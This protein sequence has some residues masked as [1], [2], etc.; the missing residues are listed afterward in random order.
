M[1]VASNLTEGVHSDCVFLCVWMQSDLSLPMLFC[2]LFIRDIVVLQAEAMSWG[3][4]SMGASD[5]GKLFA[6]DNKTKL[7]DK[8]DHFYIWPV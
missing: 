2:W 8:H 3:K 1:S 4:E 6:M 5:K 7:L